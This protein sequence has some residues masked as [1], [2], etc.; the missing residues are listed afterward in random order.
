M[1]LLTKE[2]IKSHQDAKVCLRFF[3]HIFGKRTS[4]KLSKRINHRKVTEHCDYN[5]TYRDAI[6]RICNLK[7]NVPS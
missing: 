7:F 5:S 3:F 2:E 4:K 6:H 1:L